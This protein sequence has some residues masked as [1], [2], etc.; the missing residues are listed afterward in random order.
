MGPPPRF[1][2]RDPP[3]GDH[4]R[5]GVFQDGFHVILQEAEEDHRG[6]A[7]HLEKPVE[8]GL[9]SFLLSFGCNLLQ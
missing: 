9:G 1:R 5:E 8:K 3:V 7:A 6:V 2:R 4:R